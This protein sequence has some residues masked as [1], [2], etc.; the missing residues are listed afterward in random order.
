MRIVAAV[1][2]SAA[3]DADAVLRSCGL[4]MRPPKVRC[5]SGSTKRSAIFV[6]PWCRSVHGTIECSLRWYQTTATGSSATISADSQAS[7]C[8]TLSG[9]SRIVQDDCSSTLSVSTRRSVRHTSSDAEM[10]IGDDDR[11]S[12]YTTG[13]WASMN[14]ESSTAC[15]PLPAV[16]AMRP[17]RRISS[18]RN[19]DPAA[20]GLGARETRTRPSLSSRSVSLQ[21]STRAR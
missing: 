7:R 16:M 20:N 19:A 12:T 11:I 14:S 8:T 2:S 4:S 6:S 9:A 18:W 10:L 3:S 5:S 17:S 21:A 15:S 1:T 13:S